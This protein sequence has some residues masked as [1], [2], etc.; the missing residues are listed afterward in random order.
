MFIMGT[1]IKAANAVAEA[2]A[3]FKNLKPDVGLDR[4]SSSQD[5]PR[6][7][8]TRHER[9]VPGEHADG[10]ALV[11]LKR[12]FGEQVLMTATTFSTH[13]MSP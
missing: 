11:I 5:I 12:P 13:D 6:E 4:T 7:A 10:Y 2:Q 3:I 9:V 1:T 8:V